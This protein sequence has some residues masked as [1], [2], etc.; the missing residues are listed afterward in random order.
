MHNKQ[1]KKECGE[2]WKTSLRNGRERARVHV[3][4]LLTEG[5]ACT[6]AGRQPPRG[7]AALAVRTACYDDSLS[8][9]RTCEV[10]KV[11]ERAWG[12]GGLDGEGRGQDK[13]RDADADVGPSEE[14]VLAASPR[15]GGE[16]N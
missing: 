9:L 13:A 11:A 4:T 6:H 5:L 12:D 15:D 3:G 8:A 16:E 10:L 14:V 2:K 1:N 7:P